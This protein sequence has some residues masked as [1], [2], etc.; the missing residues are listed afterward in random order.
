MTGGDASHRLRWA[1]EHSDCDPAD[2]LGLTGTRCAVLGR[3]IHHSL[4]PLLHTAAYT[5]RGLDFNYFRIEA[6][7]EHEFL[8]LLGRGEGP[9]S[10]QLYDSGVRGYSVTM[11]GKGLALRLADES[12]E[13]ARLIGS[14][15]TLLLRPDG[16]WIADN[17]DVDGVSACLARLGS[18][19]GDAVVVGNGGTARPALAAFAQAGIKK[20]SVFAR[21][22]RA[23]ELEPLAAALGLDFE[24][25]P[26]GQSES[27]HAVSIFESASVVVSTVPAEVSAVYAELILRAASVVDVIY[28]PYPTPLLE[29]AAQVGVPH[30]DGLIML[31]GQAEQQFRQFTGMAAPYG[32]MLSTACRRA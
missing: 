27:S 32:V 15:N 21:S 7:E 16:S 9:D 6:G 18:S 19:G 14:A 8:P 23:L 26:M 25:L 5:A 24:W 12:T 1:I 31:A 4:S 17:T 10:R 22:Q 28:D 3:P 20:V 2:F 29:S 13:R 11:P 30:A